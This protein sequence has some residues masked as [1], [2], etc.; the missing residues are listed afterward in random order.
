M[1]TVYVETEISTPYNFVFLCLVSIPWQEKPKEI[2]NYVSVF[3]EWI[4]QMSI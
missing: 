2:S 3:M 4:I 1:Y